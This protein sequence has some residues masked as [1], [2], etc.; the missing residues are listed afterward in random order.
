MAINPKDGK[1]LYHLTAIENLKSIIKNDLL[2]RNRL[3]EGFKNVADPDILESRKKFDLA[4]FTPFHFFSST[5]FAGSAQKANSN[6]EFIYI[7]ITRSIA[8]HNNFKIVPKHPLNY[9]EEP[10]EWEDGMNSI[11]WELI[12]DRDYSDHDCKEAC[13]AECLFEGSVP[14]KFFHAIYVRTDKAKSEILTIL[15]EEK[16][17][18]RVNV[19]PGMFI[20]K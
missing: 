8:K 10:L 7:T 17:S 1:L 15:E 6:I 5:P 13:M 4:K 9:D 16:L 12:S 11:D 19:I 20:I 14:A 2:P 18:I 3:N